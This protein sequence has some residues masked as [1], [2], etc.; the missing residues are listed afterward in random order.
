MCIFSIYFY[1]NSCCMTCRLQLAATIIINLSPVL[2][3]CFDCIIR[4][5]HFALIITYVNVVTLSLRC[6]DYNY[7]TGMYCVDTYHSGK[8]IKDS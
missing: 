5:R 2:H 4:K 8:I 3:N 7:M 6:L 1:F